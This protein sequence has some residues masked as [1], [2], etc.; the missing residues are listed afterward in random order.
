LG[1][2]V[3]KRKGVRLEKGKTRLKEYW[4][5]FHCFEIEE[6]RFVRKKARII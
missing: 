6:R 4:L 2:A 1:F 5:V 3:A